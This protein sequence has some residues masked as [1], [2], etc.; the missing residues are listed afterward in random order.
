VHLICICDPKEICYLQ[1]LILVE[2]KSLFHPT[3]FCFQTNNFDWPRIRSEIPYP[4]LPYVLKIEPSGQN[5]CWN[6]VFRQETILPRLWNVSWIPHAL[7]CRNAYSCFS[8][9]LQLLMPVVRVGL[10][11]REWPMYCTD[12]EYG[13]RYHGAALRSPYIHAV[14]HR[15]LFSFP[16]PVNTQNTH[17]QLLHNAQHHT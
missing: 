11:T 2:F 4:V 6:K 1:Y 7:L 12:S 13:E 10:P 5:P 8:L 16:P 3:A 9:L 17:I 15:P 14:S